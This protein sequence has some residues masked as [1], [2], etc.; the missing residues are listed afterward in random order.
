MEIGAQFF[1]LRDFCK[2]LDSF[3]E[4]LKKVADIGY[5]NVQISSEKNQ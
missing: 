3:A 4:S 2:D 1:T 5:K